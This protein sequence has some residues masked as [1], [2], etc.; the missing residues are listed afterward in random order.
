M[1][2]FF[3]YSILDQNVPHSTAPY[4]TAP[5][6][7]CSQPTGLNPV[8]DAVHCLLVAFSNRVAVAVPSILAAF[9]KTVAHQHPVNTAAN[10]SATLWLYLSLYT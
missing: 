3:L 10:D 6:S 7:P 4:C 9:C 1:S 8:G 2:A 5:H